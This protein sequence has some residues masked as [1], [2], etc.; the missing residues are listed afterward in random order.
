MM[1]RTLKAQAVGRGNGGNG[2]AAVA[3]G[4]DR[5]RHRW[6]VMEGCQVRK[7]AAPY[8]DRLCLVQTPLFGVYLHRI[9]QGDADRDPHDH[10]W[11][12]VSLVL[13][14]GYVEDIYE[15][16]RYV[17]VPSRDR[18]RG[19][20]SVGFMRR[21]HA[22]QITK[23]WGVLWTLVL[24]GPRGRSWRPY[25]TPNGPVDWRNYRDGGEQIGA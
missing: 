9:H 3:A 13:S 18:R 23:V 7:H 16:P 5:R 6:A 25:W 20:W 17:V 24:V 15:D 14:G 4:K 10:P 1:P 8:L 22:H 19:R 12:F 21:G 11:W 2:A